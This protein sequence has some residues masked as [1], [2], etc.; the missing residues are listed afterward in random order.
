V[1]RILV[2]LLVLIVALVVGSAL[3]FVWPREDEVDRADAIVV[4][5]GNFRHRLPDGR[6]LWERGVAPTLVLSVEPDEDYPRGLCRRPRVVCFTAKPYSTVGEA[7]TLAPIVRRRGWK[8]IVLVTSVYHV[9]RARLLFRRCVDGEVQAYGAH[10]PVLDLLHGLAWEWPKLAY[11]L[12]L[13]R[14]C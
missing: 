9:T 14:D 5:A 3:L 7:E 2:L 13:K 6:R 4:L 11:A 12:T 8:K 10:E 1:R